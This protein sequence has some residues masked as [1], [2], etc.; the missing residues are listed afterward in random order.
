M[1]KVKVWGRSIWGK[2]YGEVGCGLAL[3]IVQI[4][5]LLATSTPSLLIEN[6]C[7]FLLRRQPRTFTVPVSQCLSRSTKPLRP[8]QSLLSSS[9]SAFGFPLG[10]AYLVSCPWH[11]S[12]TGY[13]LPLPE[14]PW[15]ASDIDG[16]S[17]VLGSTVT[18]ATLLAYM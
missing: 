9:T 6:R 16:Y 5:E 8:L 7:H 15:L 4:T 14:L 3:Q 13:G 2:P 12:S 17:Y 11:S 1:L 10:P 18:A